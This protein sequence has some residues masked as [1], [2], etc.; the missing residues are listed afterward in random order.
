MIEGLRRLHTYPPQH[1]RALPYGRGHLT[2]IYYIILFDRYSWLM[3]IDTRDSILS[4]RCMHVTEPTS[5][6]LT[7]PISPSGNWA[8]ATRSPRITYRS[9]IMAM[10]NSA[11]AQSAPHIRIA[12][13]RIDQSIPSNTPKI[14]TM[15]EEGVGFYTQSGVLRPYH[16]RMIASCSSLL[17]LHCGSSSLR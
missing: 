16:S 10:I 2:S 8:F 7:P 17:L 9:M 15:H 14:Q 5:P 3:M 4:E 12:R 1:G 11:E 13:A 6:A